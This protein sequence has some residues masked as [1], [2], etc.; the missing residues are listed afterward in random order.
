MLDLGFVRANL[1][2]VEEKLRARGADPAALLGDFRALDQAR[3]E[4]ITLAEQSKAR[5]NELSQQVGALKKSGQDAT[6]VMDETRAL[7][8]KLDELDKTASLLDE[9]LRLSLAGIPNL[10]RDEV[11]TGKS[12]AENVVM[13]SHLADTAHRSWD[14]TPKPHRNVGQPRLTWPDGQTYLGVIRKW[15]QLLPC[16]RLTPAAVRIERHPLM[17]RSTMS[18]GLCCRNCCGCCCCGPGRVS[19]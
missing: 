9:Q 17:L 5:R 11:P 4:A 10:T 15:G 1:E 2:L 13:K 3:R 12:E 7:K 18:A 19:R 16:W 14:F 8:D 6:A